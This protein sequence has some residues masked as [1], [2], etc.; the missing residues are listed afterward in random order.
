MGVDNLDNTT[1]LYYDLFI[2]TEYLHCSH[3]EFLSLPRIEQEKLRIYAEVKGMKN[4]KYLDEMRS[5]Y[6]DKNFT[7]KPEVNI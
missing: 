4:E 2:C 1:P 6:E 3:S 7:D 5:K